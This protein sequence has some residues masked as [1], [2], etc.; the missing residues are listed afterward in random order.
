EDVTSLDEVTVNAG[1]YTVKERE[2]TG[3]IS[4][5]TAEEIELQPVISPIQALQGRMAGVEIIPGGNQPGMASTIRIRGR[6]SLRE[7]GNRPLYIIDGM[8]INSTPVE[9]NSVLQFTGMDPLNTLN[10]SN[11]QSIEVLKDADATAIYGSRGANGVILITTKT[12]K[13]RKTEIEARVYT[14]MSTV[15]KKLDLL[16]T[17]EYL[18]IR[19]R[20]FEND[21][22]QMTETNAYDLILWDQNRNTDWQDFFLGGTSTIT[23]INI[24]AS[25]G[26]ANTS[27]RIGSSY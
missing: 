16:N 21:Q 22:I 17:K 2:R 14:G 11:V 13:Q 4:R 20:A 3:S 7:E 25:G 9:S 24:S 23:N 27:F 10:V 18:Q 19:K 26:D 1:Y 6:N 15:P 8:P 12:P 5:V